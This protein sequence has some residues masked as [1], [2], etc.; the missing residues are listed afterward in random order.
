M[1]LVCRSRAYSSVVLVNMT[2]WLHAYTQSGKRKPELFVLLFEGSK[3]YS[4]RTPLH[5]R[6]ASTEG[7][8][9]G[10]DDEMRD[11][12]YKAMQRAYPHLA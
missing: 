1:S 7:Q 4:L 2:P 3:A 12:A 11:Q 5:M 8:R 9:T 6:D 10:N